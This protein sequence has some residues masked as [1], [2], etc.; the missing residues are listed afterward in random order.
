MTVE[1][2]S[3]AL[4]NIQKLDK[5]IQKRI[6]DYMDEISALEDPRTRGKLLVG[7][8]EGMWRF[9]VGDYR[10][11]CKIHDD[12]LVITVITVGHRREVY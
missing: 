6:F 12:K 11:I 5:P 2:L 9:R 10:I 4:K 7:N 3:R 8:L 1:Y